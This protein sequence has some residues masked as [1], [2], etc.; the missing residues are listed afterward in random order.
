MISS[1]YES[2]I[3]E[4]SLKLKETNESLNE[5]LK[6]LDN[7]L[8]ANTDIKN[9]LAKYHTLN[10][11][12]TGDV[13]TLRQTNQVIQKELTKSTQKC[14]TLEKEKHIAEEKMRSELDSLKREQLTF[15][16]DT[17][18]QQALEAQISYL[19]GEINQLNRALKVHLSIITN[20]S[21]NV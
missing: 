10:V 16:A 18:K 17:G 19:Q 15:S 14:M 4:L 13:D 8:K 6:Q 2:Q 21:I 20:L 1:N 3:S 9:E 11:K 12:L 5:K 7:L